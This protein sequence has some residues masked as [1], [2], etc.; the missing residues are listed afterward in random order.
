MSGC[1]KI[2]ACA[3]FPITTL[4][5][6]M[7][8]KIE[9]IITWIEIHD[10]ML[11]NFHTFYISFKI[12]YFV[13]S[14]KVSCLFS[15]HNQSDLHAEILP[16]RTYHLVDSVGRTCLSVKPCTPYFHPFLFI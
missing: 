4:M 15:Q 11:L 9:Y 7:Q 6:L 12:K 2:H 16:D 3:P 13:I 5:P 14:N 1:C 8:M 10:C